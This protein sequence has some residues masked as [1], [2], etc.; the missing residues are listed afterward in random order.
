MTIPIV[1]IL[2]VLAVVAIL[3][4]VVNQ[5]V[6]LPPIAKQVFNIILALATVIYLLSAVFG[7]GPSV[8]L[9]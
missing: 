5:L 9:R 8:H 3:Y 1:S 2:I 4:V 7:V 6:P